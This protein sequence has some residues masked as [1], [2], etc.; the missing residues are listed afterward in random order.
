MKA[1]S[2]KID[3]EDSR[4]QIQDLI[5]DQ[6]INAITKITFVKGAIRGNHFHKKTIQWNYLISGKILLVTQ[7]NGE[8][9]N[10]II[11]NP[12]DLVSTAI[13]ESHAIKALEE[14]VLLVFTEGP[15]GGKEYESDTYKLDEPLIT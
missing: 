7:C 14:S 10:E 11:L 1:Q 15:R 2:L 9:K 8:N 4:G 3:F 6:N 13:N 12:G 5:Q